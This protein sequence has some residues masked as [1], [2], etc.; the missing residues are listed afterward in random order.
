MKGRPIGEFYGYQIDGF[1]ESEEEVKALTPL[2][3]TAGKFDPKTYIGK[4]KYRDV[5]DDGKITK[6]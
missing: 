6:Y 3:E 1:Y 2:G 4:F 5:D